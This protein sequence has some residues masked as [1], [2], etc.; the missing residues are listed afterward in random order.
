MKAELDAAY[1]ALDEKELIIQ[2]HK[3]EA[4]QTFF[5]FPLKLKWF[6][7]DERTREVEEGSR[8]A[9]NKKSSPFRRK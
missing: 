2:S 1:K 8:K 4:N 5:N 9:K 6:I 7:T 3:N